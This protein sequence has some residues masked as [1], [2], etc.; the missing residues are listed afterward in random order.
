MSHAYIYVDQS[1]QVRVES[2]AVPGEYRVR[3][4]TVTIHLPHAKARE[5][6]DALTGALAEPEEA[7]DGH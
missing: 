4:G 6:R 3:V 5:L 7:R 2:S 1:D